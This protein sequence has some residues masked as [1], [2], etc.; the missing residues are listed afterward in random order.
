MTESYSAEQ[1]EGFYLHELRQ[2]YIDK[3]TRQS[4]AHAREID[5]LQRKL[6]E[7][8]GSWPRKTER[9]IAALKNL[10]YAQYLLN[11]IP[12]EERAIFATGESFPDKLPKKFKRQMK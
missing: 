8:D 3:F 12:V 4:E 2:F 7:D 11:Q 5:N 10:L 6:G 1:G 9:R